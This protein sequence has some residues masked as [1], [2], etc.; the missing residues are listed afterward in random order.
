[1]ETSPGLYAHFFLFVCPS[2]RNYLASVCSSSQCNLEPADAHIFALR[3]YCGWAEEL[4]GFAALRHWV[5][6]GKYVD[7]GNVAASVC[8]GWILTPRPCYAIKL[9]RPREHVPVCGLTR[10]WSGVRLQCR[11]KIRPFTL[12]LEHSAATF[13]STQ[14]SRSDARIIF[15]ESSNA[16]LESPPA[17][18]SDARVASSAKASDASGFCM[19]DIV[20]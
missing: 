2:C 18:P 9:D 11:A 12:N 7:L 8:S 16:S 14:G 19:G 13:L 4:P 1:M 5:E 6:C 15:S 10:Q 17:E 3:C 20:G